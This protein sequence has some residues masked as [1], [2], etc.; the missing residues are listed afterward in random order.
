[1]RP[2]PRVLSVR[3]RSYSAYGRAQSFGDRSPPP[4]PVLIDCAAVPAMQSAST[5]CSISANARGSSRGPANE[6]AC[7]NRRQCAK[8]ERRERPHALSA[9]R[10]AAYTV[11]LAASAALIGDRDRDGETDRQTESRRQSGCT[12]L[13]VHPAQPQRSHGRYHQIPS[14]SNTQDCTVTA[15]N[16]QPVRGTLRGSPRSTEHPVCLSVCVYL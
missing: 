10:L 13:N 2:L 3:E 1:L 14:Q 11:C 9:S 12:H 15:Q 16:I 5:S 4:L 6:C 7:T 8:A